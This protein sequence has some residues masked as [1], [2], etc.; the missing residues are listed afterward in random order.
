MGYIFH[1]ASWR[2]VADYG[3]L[4]A[5]YSFSFS[6]YYNE[7]MMGFGVLRVLNDDTIAG[8]KWFPPHGHDNMEIITI[9]QSWALEHEDNT[10]WHGIV[11]LWDV[12]V[13]SAGSWVEHSEYNAS[14]TESATLFQLWIDSREKDIAPRYDQKSFGIIPMGEISLLVSNDG[15]EGSLMIHQD[16]FVSRGSV[17]TGETLSYNPYISTNGVYVMV[18]SGRVVIN[19]E[20][21]WAKDAIGI[22]DESEIVVEATE[23]SDVL[24]IEVPMES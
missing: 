14:A 12:Q 7:A 21:L 9:P 3:W 19:G 5:N 23:N 13:M 17:W 18:V 4:Q 16:A 20:V 24:F 10:W 2:G 22:M 15:R 6:R 11:R 8:G 1:P